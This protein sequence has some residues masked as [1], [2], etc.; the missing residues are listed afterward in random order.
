MSDEVFEMMD[1]WTM[2]ENHLGTICD[3]NSPNG[4]HRLQQITNGW[5]FMVIDVESAEPIVVYFLSVLPHNVAQAQ[6]E[7]HD[8][9]TNQMQSMFDVFEFYNEHD[10]L[11]LAA[12]WHGPD[13]LGGYGR[14]VDTALFL[15]NPD[16][17]H[18]GTGAY[19]LQ[20]YAL[21]ALGGFKTTKVEPI[22]RVEG[23]EL[24]DVQQRA[25]QLACEWDAVLPS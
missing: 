18:D 15:L 19:A 9:I 11:S 22:R 17:I 25:Y 4:Y 24:E 8:L 5:L 16:V 12:Y 13:P 6:N 14:V 2:G 20:R 1:C 10:P 7:A 3:H 21:G 23:G